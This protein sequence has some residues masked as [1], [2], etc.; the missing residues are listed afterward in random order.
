MPSDPPPWRSGEPR[1]AYV[2]PDH[3]E[4]VKDAAGRCPLDQ[5]ALER[6]SL[7]MNQRLRYWCPMHPQVVA[8][9]A[10]EQCRLCGGM[11]LV[12]KV[13]HYRP[14]GEVLSVPESAVVDTG[15]VKLVYV[16]RMPGMFDGIEVELG[17]RCGDA[18]PVIR[19]L[20]PGQRVAASGAFLIDAETRLNPSLA[21]SYFG[22]GSRP[23]LDS[24][25]TASD[26][27]TPAKIAEPEASAGRCPVTRKPLGSM[28]PPVRV[29]VLGQTVQ[30][31]CEGCEVKLRADPAKYLSQR[32]AGGRAAAVTRP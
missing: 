7:G 19:G 30:L 23:A 11:P 32:K 24:D 9:H 2:C 13:V 29:T 4:T 15:K 14:H 31:C 25:A 20:E 28:G 12:A 17:P 27:S 8:D 21:S 5:N 18:F 3:P 6:R 1:A 22:A 16:E 26:S 10:G